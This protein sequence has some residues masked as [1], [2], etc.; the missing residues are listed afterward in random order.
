MERLLKNGQLLRCQLDAREGGDTNFLKAFVDP[1]LAGKLD[2]AQPRNAD[3]FSS[4]YFPVLGYIGGYDIGD[5]FPANM[6]EVTA[7]DKEVTHVHAKTEFGDAE[8]W[9]DAAHGFLPQRVKIV[10]G[11]EDLT[12][13]CGVS[14]ASCSMTKIR[15]V[16]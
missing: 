16:S 10:K 13:G 1:K 7:V 6:S 11:P 8:A 15:A 2:K 14:A 12:T 5:Y 4:G 9:I 3:V